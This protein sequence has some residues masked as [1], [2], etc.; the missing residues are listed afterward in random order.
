MSCRSAVATSPTAESRR[1]AP[2]LLLPVYGPTPTGAHV[3]TREYLGGLVAA[4]HQVDVVTTSSGQPAAVRTEDGVRI[5]P[6]GYWWRAAQTSR[7]DLV[8]SHH[9]DR[10]APA[11]PAQVRGVP[12]LL[13]VHGMSA[14]RHLGQPTLAWFP[15][16]ACRDHYPAYRGPSLVLAPPVDPE[17][18]RTTPGRLVTLNGSTAGKGADVLAAVAEQLP[19]M[20]LSDGPLGRASWRSR[21]AFACSS[22]SW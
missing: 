10:R 14:T 20:R 16:Q 21:P 12:H 18:Y 13:L 2:T 19:N 15:S 1:R 4:G 5:W 8:I 6:L 7:P 17:R 9:G 3:T 11:I 22:V